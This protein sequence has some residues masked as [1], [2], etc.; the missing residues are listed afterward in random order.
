MKIKLKDLADGPTHYITKNNTLVLN[1]N[2]FDDLPDD[3]IEDILYKAYW[4]WRQ[5]QM[6]KKG[7]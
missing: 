5:N 4:G 3:T 6:T 7:Y 2:K 1:R